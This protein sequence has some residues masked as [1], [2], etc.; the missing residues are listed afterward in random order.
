MLLHKFPPE[1]QCRIDCDVL[2]H[3]V[4]EEILL[5]IKDLFDVDLSQLLNVLLVLFNQVLFDLNLSSEND[6]LVMN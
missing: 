3:L 2:E 5:V 4:A 1:R 6:K